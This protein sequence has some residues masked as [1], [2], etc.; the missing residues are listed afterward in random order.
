MAY[1]D[2]SAENQP[3]NAYFISLNSTQART[4]TLWIRKESC[5]CSTTEYVSLVSARP[6]VHDKVGCLRTIFG[7]VDLTLNTTYGL[8]RVL[9]LMHSPYVTKIDWWIWQNF[10]RC[11]VRIQTRNLR[12]TF[13]LFYCDHKRSGNEIS[14]STQRGFRG[15]PS[16]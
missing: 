2:Q 1:P 8:E 3:S 4:Y 12:T 16:S 11:F 7:G 5:R 6:E 9:C 15:L 13:K 14:V 10:G